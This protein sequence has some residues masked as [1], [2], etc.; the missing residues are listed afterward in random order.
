LWPYIQW[1]ILISAT[2]FLCMWDLFIGQ[3]SAPYNK[4]VLTT[5]RYTPPFNLSGIFLPHNTSK[6]FFHFYYSI[7]IRWLISPLISAFFRMIDP[8]YLNF[9]TL[10][11]TTHLMDTSFAP[12][13]SPALKQQCKCSALDLLNLKYS[14]SKVSLHLSNLM[15]TP[16]LVSNS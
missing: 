7:F 2:H 4:V 12:S 8:R 3:H 15:F 5:I 16:S 6:A 10:T 1:I 14:A 11:I 13:P 9:S